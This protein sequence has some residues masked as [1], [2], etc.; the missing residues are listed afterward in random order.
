MQPVRSQRG[1]E[2]QVL[3]KA[4]SAAALG[5]EL[6][7]Q[8]GRFQRGDQAAVGVEVLKGNARRVRAV[9]LVQARLRGAVRSGPGRH[10]G[11]PWAGHCYG[12]DS[13]D[14]RR[15]FSG[16]PGRR[17]A[18]GRN[19]SPWLSDFYLRSQSDRRLMSLTRDGQDR[20]FAVLTER[21]RGE[22][23]GS[24]RRLAAPGG[25]RGHRPA[26]IAQRVCLD[27]ARGR[28]PARARVASR[29]PAACGD[30]RADAADG[31]AAAS[32]P[33]SRDSTPGL[34][35]AR[36]DAREVLAALDGLPARQRE[37][38]VASTIQ[39]LSRSEVAAVLGISEGAVRQLVHRARATVRGAVTALVPY[40]VARWLAGASSDPAGAGALL[41]G[42]ST[43]AGG[44][45]LAAAGRLGDQA[46]SDRRRRDDRRRGSGRLRR[47]GSA[48]A[49]VPPAARRRTAASTG[50][51]QR[52]AAPRPCR[53]PEPPR[54]GAERAPRG[55]VARGRR[56][57]PQPSGSACAPAGRGSALRPPSRTEGPGEIRPPRRSGGR[58]WP[59][60]TWRP[61]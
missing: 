20:A 55:P 3:L 25:G 18:S 39:G 32:T 7:L 21:Y 43:A 17:P 54:S 13:V 50:A 60:G 31:A 23:L 35:E 49:G 36:A 40:P 15:S 53:G 6:S 30:T 16:R 34:L 9:Q 38:L 56:P 10:P 48:G 47:T 2:K 14:S 4:V 8:G 58:S 12:R 52:P 28:G 51:V 5:D 22:L 37:A 29:H 42:T 24:A 57:W 19:M 44:A 46:R 61:A 1:A 41:T 45:G 59:V 33:S 26:D 27:P 11:R